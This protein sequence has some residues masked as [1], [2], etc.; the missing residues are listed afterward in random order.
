VARRHRQSEDLARNRVPSSVGVASTAGGGGQHGEQRNEL[1]LQHLCG[2]GTRRGVAGSDG[3][4]LHQALLA[5]SDDGRKDVSF[6]LDNGID[7]R[8]GPRGRG[9]CRERPRAG[10]PRGRPPSPPLVHVA[11]LHTGMGGTRR[12]GRGDRS[13][14]ASGAALEGCLRPGRERQGCGRVDRL[15]RRIRPGEPGPPGHLPG[16]ASGLLEPEDAPRDGL[17][18][19]VDVGRATGPLGLAPG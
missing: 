10:H 9:S 6:R 12:P 17:S 3:P 16:L 15:P 8:P 13:G 2:G 1:Q 11:F 5:A 19:P 18:A 4:C 14:V 7:L